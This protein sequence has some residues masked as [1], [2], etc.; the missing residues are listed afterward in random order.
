MY[1][2]LNKIVDNYNNQVFIDNLKY[3]IPYCEQLLKT[4]L[5]KITEDNYSKTFSVNEFLES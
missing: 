2:K 1:S 3:I 5:H 4:S